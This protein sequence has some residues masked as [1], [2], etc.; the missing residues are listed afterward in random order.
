LGEEKLHR[1]N[2]IWN[3]SKVEGPRAMEFCGGD[4]VLRRI[5]Y[6]R[7]RRLEEV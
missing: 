4:E 1:C 7:G 2:I 3:G 5:N 6:P